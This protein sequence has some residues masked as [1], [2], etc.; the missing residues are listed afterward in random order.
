MS[1][2]LL[3]SY[4]QFVRS[5]DLTAPPE[6]LGTGTIRNRILRLYCVHFCAIITAGILISRIPGLQD[7]SK[8]QDMFDA[9]PIG[10]LFFAGVIMA[11]VL[12][13]AIFRLP[14]RP[15]IENL[16][17][18]ASLFIFVVLGFFADVIPPSFLAVAM[19]TMIGLTLYLFWRRSRRSQKEPAIRIAAGPLATLVFYGFAIL[20]GVVH[21][22]NYDMAVWYFLPLV[23]MP[24]VI[25]GF[26]LGFVRLRY[27]YI[28][29]VLLHAFHNFCAILPLFVIK[30]FG[31]ETLQ[32]IGEDLDMDTLSIPDYA[33]LSVV[34]LYTMAGLTAC[35]VITW[36]MIREMK[37]QP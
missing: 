13:E 30:L 37:A 9:T 34:G 23:V 19:S 6:T 15:Y 35:V 7:A 3:R 26:L 12:E 24:Q 16:M 27:G 1:E 4:L 2:S 18:A 28:W 17:L 25:I 11:P 31:S 20:F 36:Q 21:I 10:P 5:P 32:V 22:T 29:A 14:L 33:V 8:I